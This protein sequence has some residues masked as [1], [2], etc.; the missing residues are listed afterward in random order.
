MQVEVWCNK[1][2]KESQSGVMVSVDSVV[3]SIKVSGVIVCG[4]IIVWGE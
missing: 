3:D 4:E 1:V 2:F